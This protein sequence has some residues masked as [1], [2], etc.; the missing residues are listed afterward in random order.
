[1]ECSYPAQPL[2][3]SI[4][5]DHR[6]T[7]AAVILAAMCVMHFSKPWGTPESAAPTHSEYNYILNGWLTCIGFVPV[8]LLRELFINNKLMTFHFWSAESGLGE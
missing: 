7:V 4:P 3:D 5:V 1:M 6:T 8:F 2:A